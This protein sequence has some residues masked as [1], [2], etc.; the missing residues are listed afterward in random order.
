MP[1]A[2]RITRRL[3]ET[4][5]APESTTGHYY[6]MEA[7][8]RDSLRGFGLHVYHASIRYVVRRHRITYPLGRVDLVPL[9]QARE[10]ARNLLLQLQSEGDQPAL[11]GRRKTVAELSELFLQQVVAPRNKPKT[12]E[13]YRR[14]WRLHLLPRFGSLRLPQVTPERVLQMKHDLAATPVAANRSLQQ[15]AA[16]FAFAIRL[17]WVAKNPADQR[18]VD[19]YTEAP[20][21]R[22]LQPEEY[23][24]LGAALREAE[25]GALFPSRTVAAIRLL[26]LTGARPHEILSAEL[27]WV[28]FA[29]FPRINRPDA[30]GDRPGKRPR[31][32]SIWLPPAA[33]EII[34][35][36]PRPEGCRW[37]IPG[38]VPDQPLGDVDKAWARVCKMAGVEGATPKS[39]RHS[40]RSAG[41]DAGIAPDHMRELMGH[42]TSRMTDKVYWHP[43]ASAQAQAAAEIG[44][45]LGKLL[46]PK[47]PPPDH[48]VS[49]ST[50]PS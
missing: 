26:L 37:L 10:S 38:D 30:K 33:V 46:E 7:G 32:R 48:R 31:G 2:P 43:R 1:R 20:E 13:E 15:L 9:E 25:A 49:A 23:Q 24:R 21:S 35:S 45:Y 36:I 4:L 16:A 17:E 42:T 18:K 22:S 41:P 14:L 39:A 5:E 8:G 44:L 29:P 6:V 3:I 12:L 28:D 34:R 27:A 47:E 11:A 19:R 40:F 50:L